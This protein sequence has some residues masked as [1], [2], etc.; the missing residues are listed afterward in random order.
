MHRHLITVKIGIECRADKRMQLQ[1]LALD[2]NRF[3]GL[4]PQPVQ[5]RGPVQQDR[6][7]FDDIVQGVPD[8]RNLTLHHFFGTFDGGYQT[9]L[10][11]P[12]VNKGLE[13]LQRHF[14]G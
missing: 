13:Q 4:D 3:K 10:L 1:G 6:V 14:F 5:G 2:E 11:E 12:V 8:F 7:F 9:L